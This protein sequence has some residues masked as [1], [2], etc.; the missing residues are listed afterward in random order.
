[1][2]DKYADIINL[3]RHVSKKRAPMPI[4]DRAA[5]FAPFAALTGHKAAVDETARVTEKRIELDPYLKEEIDNK[6]EILLMN[7]EDRPEVEITYFVLDERKVGGQYVTTVG[8]LNKIDEYKKTILIDKDKIIPIS[9]ILR[10]DSELF[11]DLII[12]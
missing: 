8:K 12:L 3:P 1:M 9:E 4:K 11:N 10:I 6:L 5:Q 2:K 7:L